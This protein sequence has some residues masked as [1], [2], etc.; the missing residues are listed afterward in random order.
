M[1]APLAWLREYV[2]LPASTAQVANKL[3]ML[4]FPVDAIE[5]RP[6]ITGVVVGRI[7]SIEKHPN[8]DRLQVCHVDVGASAPLIIATAATNVAVGQTI[9]VATIGAKLPH[10]TIERRKMRGVESEGMMCSA[11]ELA[12]NPE[13]FED[14]IMQ[15]DDDLPLGTDV[16]AHFG[17]SQDILDTEITSNRV[18]AMSIIGLARELAAAF[19]APLTLPSFENPGVHDAA[20]PRVTLE[21]SDCTQF[22]AQRFET[23]RNGIAPAWMRIRLALAGQRPIDRIVD[24]SNYVMLETGQPL[25]FYDAQKVTGRHFVV[26]DARQ[27]E[28]FTTLDDTA[29]AL[30]PQMLVVADESHALGLA[31]LKGGKDSGIS[32]STTSLI[33]ESATFRG[34]R[35][36]AMSR[37]LGLRTDASSRHEKTLPSIL[38]DWGAARAAQLLVSTGAQA[39]LPH[40]F[41]TSATPVGEIELTA[42]DVERLLGIAIPLT[43]IQAHLQALGCEA[44]VAGTSLKVHPPQ[45]RRDLTIPVDLVEEVARL[46]GYEGIVPVL[47]NVPVHAVSSAQ[48]RLEERLA[49]ALAAL[50]YDELLTYSLHG[51]DDAMRTAQAGIVASHLSVEVRNPLSEE[52]RYLRYTLAPAMLAHLARR[53]SAARVFE[54][55]HVFYPFGNEIAETNVLTFGMTVEARDEP[56]WRDSGF[57]ELKSDVEALIDNVTGRTGSATADNRTGLHPGKCATL[58]IDGAEVA[59][60]GR[61]DPRLQSAYD[62]KRPTYIAHVYI[63]RLPDHVVPHYIPPSKFPSTYRDLALVLALDVSAQRVEEVILAAVGPLCTSVRVFDEYRGAQVGDGRKSLAVRITLQHRDATITDEQADAAMASVTAALQSEL[64]ATLRS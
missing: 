14:G 13:W 61:L 20:A 31:G 39:F 25:H 35:V 5:R 21:S 17:L 8:A 1:R 59:T 49:Q 30:T 37:T 3:A 47:P 54:I 22:I 11:D 53:G 63:D 4:G 32:A 27:G 6:E 10:L 34:S 15:L 42:H 7:V 12:L 2:T 41:G 28:S 44:R 51:N 50:G 33:L 62:I 64:G 56:A 29:L 60:F 46:E 45:W 23:V 58:L 36:R 52:Q 40:R 48:Y 16:V 9:P 18:D 43:R 19:G 26:R 24:I 55:G 57:L 38:A